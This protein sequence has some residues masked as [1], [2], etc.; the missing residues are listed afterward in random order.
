MPSFEL[1]AKQK[2]LRA[3]LAGPETHNLI[4]GGSR[5]GKTFLFCYATATRAIRASESRH[6]IARFR[7]NHVITSVAR[8]TFPKMMRLAYPGV[9]YEMNKSDWFVTLPNDAQIWFGGLDD[10]ER[11]EKILGNEYATIYVNECSQVSYGAI[12]TLRSRLAQ[13]VVDQSGRPLKL[14]AYYDLNPTGTQHWSNREF[15]QG[16]DPESQQKLR[17]GDRV[18]GVINPAD[19]PHLPAQY[20]QILKD[21][22]ERSRARFLEGRFI[23]EVPGA[24]WK[25]ET[26]EKHRRSAGEE[27]EARD[28]PA[29]RRIVV[30]IDPN[31]KPAA[32]QW[33][34]AECGIVV[35]GLG[36]DGRSYVL[37]DLSERIGP[38]QWASK[39]VGAYHGWKADRII[40]EA[41]NGGDMVRITLR[42]AGPDVPVSL[43][44]ASRGKIT[45]AEPVSAL[46]EQGKVSHV[47]RF[48][49]LEDQ[50]TSY[51][52]AA[53][54]VSPDR[55]DALVWA[56]SALNFGT[57]AEPSIRTL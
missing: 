52:G 15:V 35:A 16:V 30:A 43:V 46:Y 34:V 7:L 18:Y 9:P 41:N 24:L 56:L 45:R 13:N 14:K 4:F 6:L 5:S 31:T 36:D 57:A 40:A 19:N 27:G 22:P 29:M 8:D 21:M 48:P 53:G 38:S 28:L 11:V 12:T 2:E 3:L 25:M 42:T 17:P 55:M 50:M 32:D 20:L 37:A 44:H 10:K 26:L 33:D 39:A 51:T 23:N 47:G 49:A 1:T 54:E